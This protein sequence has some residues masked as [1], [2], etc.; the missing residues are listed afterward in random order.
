VWPSVAR[1]VQMQD[2]VFFSIDARSHGAATYFRSPLEV[3]GLRRQFPPHRTLNNHRGEV[4]EDG[5]E[6]F[7]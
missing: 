3:A 7:P 2:Y 1:L 5:Q 6:L 4:R